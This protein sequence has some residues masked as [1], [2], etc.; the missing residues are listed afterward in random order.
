MNTICNPSA[1]WIQLC[2]VWL[3]PVWPSPVWWSGLVVAGALV[4]PVHAQPGVTLD[5]GGRDWIR[6]DTSFLLQLDQTLAPE[7]RLGVL[8]GGRDVTDLFERRGSTLRYRAELLPLDPGPTEIVVH[9]VSPDGGW[10]EVA[11]FALKILSDRGF[12]TVERA[13]RLNLSGLAVVDERREPED[14]FLP[15]TPDSGTLSLGGSVAGSRNSWRIAAEADLLGVTEV[16]SALR[17]AS[18]GEEADQLDLASWAVRLQ[19]QRSGALP[20]EIGVGHVSWSANRLL[21]GSH[22]S[23][24]LTFTI[25]GQ[26][27]ALSVAA[28]RGRAVVGWDDPFGLGRSTDLVLGGEVRFQL[29]PAR[30]GGLE[31]GLAWLDGELET[32]NPFNAALVTDRERSRGFGLSVTAATP[33]QR[34]KVDLVAARSDFENPFDEL[35]ALGG[36]LVEV[37]PEEREAYSIST[38]LALVQGVLWGER[39]VSVVLAARHER[40]DPQYRTVI[41]TPA[42]DLE[43]SAA[44]LRTQL[45]PAMVQV[46]RERSQDNLEGIPSIL[47]TR[48]DR[49]TATVAVGLVELF[50]HHA[51]PVFSLALARTHQR[52][53]GVPINADFA[54]SHVPDQVSDNANAQLDWS[55]ARWRASYRFSGS[56]QDNRQVGRELADFEAR[57][58]GLA[59][60]WSP[61]QRIDLGLELDRE[62][63][64]SVEADRLD[65]TRR[66][67]L[68]L[69]WRPL[70]RFNFDSRYS[71]SVSEDDPRTSESESRQLDL[72]LAWSFGW[73]GESGRAANGQLFLRYSDQ[74]LSARDLVFN[75]ANATSGRT[76]TA[77]LNL[78]LQ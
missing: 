52:G 66:F 63:S 37:E 21:A 56:D 61:H 3:S 77:G 38:E 72:G 50:G 6:R 40:T 28:T 24:G 44:E 59:L 23:R 73:T 4:A 46:G 34:L 51:W 48:T 25:P 78:S 76:V 17:F 18:E 1:K 69:T 20:L 75:F 14:P 42:A 27:A 64:L 36:N 70:D 16:S 39:T 29:M 11:R 68:T 22:A 74:E 53:L 30:P 55:F 54:A 13:P 10:I 49:T 8:V 57:T 32:S 5:T 45:G 35:L 47:T 33:G 15:G 62:R 60:G 7:L 12:E 67:G 26:R 58:H 19:R 43:T 2:A 31:L 9:T 41:A 65:A 71:R